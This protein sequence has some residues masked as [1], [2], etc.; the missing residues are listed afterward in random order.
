MSRM[1]QDTF[2]IGEA[3]KASGLSVKAIR[4]YEEIGLIPRAARRNGAARSGGHRLFEGGAVR[5]L[6]FIRHSRLL[7]LSLDEVR[8]LLDGANGGCPG[9]QPGYRERLAS[10]LAAIEERVEQLL[11]LKATIEE[12]LMSDPASMTGRCRMT[13]QASGTSVGSRVGSSSEPAR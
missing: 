2:T 10:H 13:L 8:E 6:R 1:D 11:G 3:A 4:Y 5:R 7:G 12:I 9:A